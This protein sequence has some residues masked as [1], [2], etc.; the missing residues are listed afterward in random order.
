MAKKAA[1]KS[2]SGGTTARC[3]DIVPAS[4]L[5]SSTILDTRVVYCGDN[6]EQLAK[7]PDACVDLIYIDPPFNSNR[8]YDGGQSGTDFWGETKEK[9]AFED[10][11]ENTKADID[12]LRPR[13]VQLARVL[14][15]TGSFYYHCDWHAIHYVKVM[16]DQI[17]GE[18]NFN[19]FGLLIKSNRTIVIAI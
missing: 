3:A 5:K 15:Q 18:Y 9:R 12:Y 8:N 2:A 14:K 13:C 6:L 11:H 10:R 4:R 19:N 16:L 1:A 17:F 7:L